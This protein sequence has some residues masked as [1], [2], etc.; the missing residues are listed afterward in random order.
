MIMHE[1]LQL[2]TYVQSITGS[3]LGFIDASII[4]TSINCSTLMNRKS[5]ETGV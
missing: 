1:I 4:V 2:L 3:Q 5:Q